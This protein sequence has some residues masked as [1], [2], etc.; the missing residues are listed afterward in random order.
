MKLSRTVSTK[1]V[2]PQEVAKQLLDTI[3]LY[4]KAFNFCCKTAF[5]TKTFNTNALQKITY[6]ECKKYLPA[7]LA[8]SANR[9]E[10]GRAHV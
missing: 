7:Q 9:T 4:T 10:I 8:V 3:D 5:A 2:L 6:T 1:L